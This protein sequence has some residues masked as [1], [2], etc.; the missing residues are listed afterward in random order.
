VVD[1]RKAIN[2]KEM[3][4]VPAW[5]L[6]LYVKPVNSEEEVELDEKLRKAHGDFHNLIS[7]YKIDDENP[8][9]VRL[10]SA[11]M[12]SFSFPTFATLLHNL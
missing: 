6:G 2:N 10:S 7:V 8:I 11:G 9:V 5:K 12:S 4:K 1:L 3:L